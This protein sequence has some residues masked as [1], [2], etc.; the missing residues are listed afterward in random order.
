[1]KLVPVY[2]NPKEGS[3]V[4]LQNGA[5]GYRALINCI[6]VVGECSTPRKAKKVAA[7]LNEAFATMEWDD[8]FSSFRATVS[9]GE[10]PVGAKVLAEP[11]R[12]ATP[13]VVM[14]WLER[15]LPEPINGNSYDD[16]AWE[17]RFYDGKFPGWGILSHSLLGGKACSVA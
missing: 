13:R 3:W 11:L 2:M 9:N 16:E 7:A 15:N 14:Q 10:F 6:Y 4:L 8:P 1:M 17:E 5:M 12:A